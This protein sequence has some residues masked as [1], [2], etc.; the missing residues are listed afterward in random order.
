MLGITGDKMLS[1]L[2]RIVG[3]HRPITADVFLT[4]YCN[5]S[6]PY[7]TYR[8]WNLEDGAYSMGYDE[9]VLYAERLLSFGV[10]GIILTGGGEPTVCRDFEKI[11]SWMESRGIHYGINTNFN[12]MVCI[13]PDY[14]KVSL[15]GWDEDSYAEPPR[16]PTLPARTKKYPVVCSMEAREQPWH[17]PGYPVCGQICGRCGKVLLFQWG[18]GR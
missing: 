10:Q 8:R 4:N 17:V 7:C 13:K 12:R 14:L 15:D 9:F 2:D 5:N 1:H 3:D 16:R 6:C 18:P 11:T